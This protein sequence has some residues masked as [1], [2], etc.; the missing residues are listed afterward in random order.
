MSIDTDIWAA[1]LDTENSGTAQPAG[2][3]ETGRGWDT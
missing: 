2:V 1:G 3:A